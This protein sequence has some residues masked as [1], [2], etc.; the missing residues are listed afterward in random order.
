M[1]QGE[2]TPKKTHVTY[3]ILALIFLAT[4][5]NSVDPATLSVAAPARRSEFGFDAITMGLALSAFGWAYTA[6]Q[7]PKGWVLDKYGV[8]LVYGSVLILWSAFTVMQGLVRIVSFTFVALFVLLILMGIVESPVPANSRLTVMWFPTEER[9]FAT[10]I[11]QSAQYLALAVFTPIMT[12]I[13]HAHSWQPIFPWAGAVGI[14]LGIVWLIDALSFLVI[15][16]PRNRLEIRVDGHAPD[17]GPALARD[18]GT[19]RA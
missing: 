17:V 15:V 18:L 14:V 19:A 9:A 10:S 2:R 11:F 5:S 3:V 8:R 7:T 4:T 16:G 1:V 13:L 12:W 6:M